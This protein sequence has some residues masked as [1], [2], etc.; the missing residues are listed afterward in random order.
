MNPQLDQVKNERMKMNLNEIVQLIILELI[1]WRMSGGEI[2][3]YREL[4]C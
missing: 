2:H 1:G 4:R 3:I